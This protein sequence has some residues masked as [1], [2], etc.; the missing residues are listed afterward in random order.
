M[1]FAVS[2]FQSW[3]R[4]RR[5]LRQRARQQLHRTMFPKYIF[6]DVRHRRGD[7]DAIAALSNFTI[8]DRFARRTDEL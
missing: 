7:S 3:I 2:G 8:D 5:A 4:E 1:V 6:F